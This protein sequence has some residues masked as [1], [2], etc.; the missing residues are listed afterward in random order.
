M[1]RKSLYTASPDISYVI[2]QAAGHIRDH[3][4][5]KFPYGFFKDIT[6]GTEEASIAEKRRIEESG[7]T[8]GAEFVQNTVG[9]SIKPVYSLD[10]TFGETPDMHDDWMNMMKRRGQMIELDGNYPKIFSDDETD[11]MM[12]TL[13]KNQ[14]VKYDIAIRLNSE[15]QAWDVLSHLKNYGILEQHYYLDRTPMGCVI[16]NTII[17]LAGAQYGY[18]LNNPVERT[19]F[20]DIIRKHSTLFID[21]I[22]DPAKKQEFYVFQFTTNMLIKVAV[23]SFDKQMRE[24]STFNT[25]VTF[26][27]ETQFQAPINFAITYGKIVDDIGHIIKSTNNDRTIIRN[28]TYRG[29]APDKE[30]ID[31][32]VVKGIIFHRGYV[33]DAPSTEDLTQKQLGDDEFPVLPED[34]APWLPSTLPGQVRSIVTDMEEELPEGRTECIKVFA[35]EG[36]WELELIEKIDLIR[37]GRNWQFRVRMA[38][39][40]QGYK[41]KIIFGEEEFEMEFTQP[42]ISQDFLFPIQAHSDFA[43]FRIDPRSWN[44]EPVTLWLLETEQKEVKGTILSTSSEDILDFGE[45][46]PDNIVKVIDLK[47]DTENNDIFKVK[48]TQK[49][50]KVLEDNEVN[51]DW[52]KK[53][54]TVDNP[55]FNETHYM[56][57]YA[58]LVEY[59]KT[60]REL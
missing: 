37:R 7:E 4:L 53:R 12:Y 10:A 57:I 52:S 14:N 9:I 24:Q 36:E 31:S 32:N 40:R 11:T 18:N 35:E 5:S 1:A 33:T 41:A 59:K 13:L 42:N 15:L 51:V 44:P 47:S 54:V 20:L 58:D 45:I 60:L 38:C 16:P 21:S 23:P 39:S 30:I 55:R 50:G 46:V 29:V 34:L 3:I 8:G 43:K 25:E 26:N 28:F 48:I 17:Y 19:D 6:F 56:S 27:I 2:S 22:V 49:G